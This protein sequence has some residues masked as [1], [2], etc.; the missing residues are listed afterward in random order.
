MWAIALWNRHTAGAQ[1]AEVT[2]R[3]TQRRATARRDIP[4]TDVQAH[5]LLAQARHKQDYRQISVPW[6][7]VSTPCIRTAGGFSRQ[8]RPAIVAL[9]LLTIITGVI[10]PLVVTGIAQ[11]VFPARPTAASSATPRARRSARG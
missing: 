8:F 4:L 5:Y 9:V 6:L 1:E 7:A 10:Y 2:L 3:E 11:V